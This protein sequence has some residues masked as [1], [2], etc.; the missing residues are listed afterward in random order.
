MDGKIISTLLCW[1]NFFYT[2]LFIATWICEF[3]SDFF[4]QIFNSHDFLNLAQNFGDSPFYFQ[5][6]PVQTLENSIFS[7]SAHVTINFRV[8]YGG[9][10]KCTTVRMRGLK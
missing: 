10:K 5:A 7:L 1:F 9:E 4:L 6:F 3:L 8:R 2:F